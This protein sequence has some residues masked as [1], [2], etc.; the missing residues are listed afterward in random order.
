ME[1]KIC[2]KCNI[3]KLLIEF[4]K[5]N[6]EKD[7]YKSRCK[8]CIKEHYRIN[9]EKILKHCKKYREDNKEIISK[10]RKRYYQENKEKVTEQVRKYRE[11]NKEKIA[12]RDKKYRQTEHSKIMSYQYKLKRKSHKHK[13]RFTPHERQYIL[14]RDNWECQLCG[15]KVHDICKRVEDMTIEERKHK[16]HIDHIIP[17]S[18]GGT[19][20]PSNLRV[21]CPSCNSSK[22]NKQNEQLNLFN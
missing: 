3:D 10:K 4:S 7:G 12:E 14:N 20:D 9:K 6:K 15:I 22:S 1:T 16:A 11:A 17:I 8:E 18:K 5:D 2:R 19:S 13:V 21:L